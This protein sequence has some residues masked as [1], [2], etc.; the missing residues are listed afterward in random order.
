MKY[1]MFFVLILSS[2]SLM[3]WEAVSSTTSSFSVNQSSI[4]PPVERGKIKKKRKKKKRLKSPK[5]TKSAIDKKMGWTLLGLSFGVLGL[6][7]ISFLLML[8]SG[9]VMG[10]VFFVALVAMLILFVL[11]GELLSL[12]LV[13]LGRKKDKERS[14]ERRR[15]DGWVF[16][17]VA[18]SFLGLGLLGLFL[19]IF[20]GFFSFG[21]LIFFSLGLFFLISVV[22]VLVLGLYH[23]LKYPKV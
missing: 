6:V 10:S 5:R 2:I 23:L 16:M 21:L 11:W 12:S 13:F 22:A 14:D 9:G 8:L 15:K 7:L 18:L 3:S 1:L 17:I 19:G 20:G 4:A